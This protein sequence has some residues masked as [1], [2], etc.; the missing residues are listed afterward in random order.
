[1]S[2]KQFEATDARELSDEMLDATSGGYIYGTSSSREV[3]ND[4]TGEVIKVFP[5]DQSAE[6]HRFAAHV[7]ALDTAITWYE[8]RDL[9]E[10]YAKSVAQA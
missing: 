8:L 9:R 1:M 4:F 5:W 3:I 10:R 7:G 6:A 2:T